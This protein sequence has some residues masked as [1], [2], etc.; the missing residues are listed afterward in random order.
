MDG[1]TDEMRRW[2]GRNSVKNEWKQ[3]VGEIGT[4]GK[5]V[6]GREGR[7]KVT[8]ACWQESKERGRK[9]GKQAGWQVQ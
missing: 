9:K 5:E 2:I 1:Q 4:G 7:D 8:Q 3:K 6:E